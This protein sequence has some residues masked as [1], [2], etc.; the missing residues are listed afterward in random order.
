MEAE[1]INQIATIIFVSIH[2][3]DYLLAKEYCETN[4]K[5]CPCSFCKLCT[6][7]YLSFKSLSTVTG[8]W[9]SAFDEAKTTQVPI[10][11][12]S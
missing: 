4:E 3:C 10:L 12:E 11:L 7:F 5:G 2:L 8:H 6:K 1:N 9:S